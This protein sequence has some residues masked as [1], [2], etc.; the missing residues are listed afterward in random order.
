MDNALLHVSGHSPAGKIEKRITFA[1]RHARLYLAESDD[2]PDNKS[3]S[4]N[5]FNISCGGGGSSS[6]LSAI[7]VSVL[8]TSDVVRFE[9]SLDI[10]FYQMIHYPVMIWLIE[11]IIQ[12]WE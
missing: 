9:Y 11:T 4:A 3:A 5:T 7:T 6:S 1:L 2:E 10:Y 12:C 8:A